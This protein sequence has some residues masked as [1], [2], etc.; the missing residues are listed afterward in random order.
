MGNVYGISYNPIFITTLVVFRTAMGCA[1]YKDEIFA[2]GGI[3]GSNGLE[4]FSP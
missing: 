3:G 2:V 1:L 4:K